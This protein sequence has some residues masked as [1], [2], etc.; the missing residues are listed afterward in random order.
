[1]QFHSLTFPQVKDREEKPNFDQARF[2]MEDWDSDFVVTTFDQLFYSF[3][4]A[5][6][7]FIRRFCRLP[8]S[9]IILD[10]VQT[11][12]TRI[13][14]L[15]ETFF[16][17]MSEK[18]DLK[19]LYMTATKPRFLMQSGQV[20][21]REEQFFE[22]LRRTK[23]I[24]RLEPKPFEKYLHSVPAFLSKRKTQT[25]MFTT[26]TIP[27]SLRFLDFLTDLKN[28]QAEF[29]EMMIFYISG[30]IVP[31]E[32][33]RRIR[34]IKEVTSSVRRDFV[35]VLSTQCVEAGV[36]IDVDEIVRDLAPWDSLMQICGRANRYGTKP[37]APVWVYR[38]VDDRAR[39]KTAFAEYVYDKVLLDTTL[40]VLNGHG[41]LEESKYFDVQAQYVRK[42]GERLF[43]EP[44]R[45]ITS[46]ALSWKFSEINEF[47][48]LFREGDDIKTSVFCVADK[49]AE[50]L[51]DIAAALWVDKDTS[52]AL[53]KAETL[54]ASED[55]K[56][57]ADFLR[58]DQA[59][60]RR[61]IA[62]VKS[63]DN[64]S[65]SFRMHQML[66]PMLQAYTVS[67]TDKALEGLTLHSLSDLFRYIERADYESLARLR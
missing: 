26:N 65:K 13:L 41:E 10:E 47:R 34:K 14:P 33:I 39:R 62:E 37:C 30:A 19:V 43:D 50:G 24:V 3:L 25:T 8:G 23:L 63:K 48:R 22:K 17:R 35:V 12:P 53:S 32:R 56:D 7:S 49:L 31:A 20:V 2:A 45:R 6:R 11:I 58:V 5:Q 52:T 61:M 51:R 38:W 54:V 64:R 28:K 29:S 21:P 59:S 44:Y 36:D 57:L 67:L 16:H 15:V 66:T 27:C 4:S 1:M 55:F 18:I 46:D 40:E 60:L 9:T 42:L